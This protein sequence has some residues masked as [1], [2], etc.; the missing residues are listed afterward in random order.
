MTS[1]AHPPPKKAGRHN[2][3]R[4]HALRSFFKGLNSFKSVNIGQ[5]DPDITRA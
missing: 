1:I 5:T 4:T 3:P 2:T